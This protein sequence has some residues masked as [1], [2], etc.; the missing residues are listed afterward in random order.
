M[1]K[2]QFRKIDPYDW[3]CGPGSHMCKWDLDR[4]YSFKWKQTIKY[5]LHTAVCQS[6]GDVLLN[7]IPFCHTLD[8]Q[9]VIVFPAGSSDVLNHSW[10]DIAPLRSY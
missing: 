9:H 5:V 2:S 4:K 1:Y 10:N 6:S 3:F 8:I 7:R